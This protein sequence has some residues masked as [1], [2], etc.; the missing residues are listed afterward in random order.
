[1]VKLLG[2]TDDPSRAAF[3]LRDGTMVDYRGAIYGTHGKLAARTS[4][5]QFPRGRTALSAFLAATG[6]VRTHPSE[7]QVDRGAYI[8]VSARSWPTEA[9]RRQMRRL[10]VGAAFVNVDV[11]DPKVGL[12][13]HSGCHDLE[14]KVVEVM[15]CL[16]THTKYK[17]RLDGARDT[18]RRRPAKRTS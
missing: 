2:T 4:P 13:R 3:I 12:T 10:L 1:M 16:R 5:V 7:D 18:S 9:Q 11:G 6:A 14:P 8:E 17:G 15:K